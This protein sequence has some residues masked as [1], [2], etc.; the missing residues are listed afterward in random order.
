MKTFGITVHSPRLETT[1]RLLRRRPVRALVLDFD[2]VF[3]D[4]KVIVAADGTESVI[5]DRSDGLAIQ[6]L[7]RRGFPI[8]VL[9]AETVPI[10]KLRCKKLGLECIH[11]AA[12]KLSSLQSWLKE[13]SVRP[14]H[15][16]YVGNDVNDIECLKFV[17][18]SFAVADAFPEARAVA[19]HVLASRGGYGAVRE[20]ALA[21]SSVLEDKVGAIKGRRKI[22]RV[23]GERP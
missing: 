6:A 14:E 15:A 17:G 4:N 10:V 23:P 16:I 22:P 7:Q 19:K 20:I 3:T 1:K 9:S 12:N 13:K 5:C 18:L 21:I 11:S 2:G 8:L